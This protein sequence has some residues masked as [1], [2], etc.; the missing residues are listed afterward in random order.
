[1]SEPTINIYGQAA[2]HDAVRIVANRDALVAL[3]DAIDS[4][5][6]HNVSSVD[7]VFASDGEAYSIHIGVMPDD[8]MHWEGAPPPFY[9]KLPDVSA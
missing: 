6:E 3:R 4:A 5:L 2:W 8:F 7:E 1:M 9:H